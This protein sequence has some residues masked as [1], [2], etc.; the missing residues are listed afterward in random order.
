M[1]THKFAVF[2][3]AWL[4]AASIS[5][6][7]VK[8]VNKHQ[9]NSKHTYEHVF[10]LEQTTTQMGVESQVDLEQGGTYTL[11]VGKRRDDGM[12]PIESTIESMK[13]VINGPGGSF[14]FDSADT[15]AAAPDNPQLKSAQDVLRAR[16]GAS[17][18]V[19]LDKQG[20]VA[21]IEGL[22]KILDRIQQANPDAV[23]SAKMSLSQEN[24]KRTEAQS[25][26]LLPDTLLRPGDSWT[27]TEVKDLGAGQT[28]TFEKRYE[29]AGTVEKNGKTLDK[30]TSKSSSVKYALAPSSVVPATV[31]SSEL[32]LLESS[33]TILFDREAGMLVESD[34]HS[35]ID[36]AI[37]LA[38]MGQEVKLELVL[39]LNETNRLKK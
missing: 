24:V 23:E 36:G 38:V 3:L 21:S 33:G 9:E 28:L 39:T 4:C 6:A 5:H 15:G 30:I 16:V 12:L 14:T 31:K 34:D 2:A 26:E 18:T 17:H 8:L 25:F 35:K 11:A 10:K 20:K 22:E 19:V 27:R 7:Q 1:K 32:K 13:V 37:D 29:Y